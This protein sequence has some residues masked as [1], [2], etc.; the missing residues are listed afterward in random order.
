MTFLAATVFP[1][2]FFCTVFAVFFV[3][4]FSFAFLPVCF[5]NVASSVVP[6]PLG[7]GHG[8]LVVPLCRRSACHGGVA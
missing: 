3:P 1:A 2:G 6:V 5:G 8:L 4:F 7:L